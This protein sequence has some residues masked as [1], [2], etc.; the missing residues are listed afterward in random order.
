MTY[1][2]TVFLH[3]TSEQYIPVPRL[4]DRLIPCGPFI[5]TK[6]ME[7]GSYESLNCPAGRFDL[8]A[9]LAQL[10]PSQRPEAVVIWADSTRTLEPVNL[11]QVPGKRVLIIGDTHHQSAPI[12]TLLNYALSE[13]YDAYAIVA[14]PHHA[15][16]FRE[17]GCRPLYWFP[18]LLTTP[19]LLPPS[20]ER[21]REIALIGQ[22]GRIHPRRQRIVEAL[23]HL[24][25]PIRA[26][27]LFMTEG[28]MWYNR[29]LISLN[30]SL[31]GDLNFRP[32]EI[33]AAGGFMLTDRLSPEAGLDR[34]YTEGQHYIAYDSFPD[35]CDK[36]DH[37]LAHPREAIAIATVA[38]RHYL[39]TMSREHVN[40]RFW[41]AILNDRVEE[42][43]DLRRDARFVQ[44]AAVPVPPET[45]RQAIGLYEFVQELHRR[46]EITEVLLLSPCRLASDI[47]DM[48]RLRLWRRAEDH[49]VFPFPTRTVA[50]AADEASQRPWV[51]VAIAGTK[52]FSAARLREILAAY[53]CDHLIIEGVTA[54]AVG[55][56][57]AGLEGFAVHDVLPVVTRVRSDDD[58]AT[59]NPLLS[60]SEALFSIAVRHHQGG[61]LPEAEQLYR[62]L[63]EQNPENISACNNLGVIALQS[64]CYLEAERL[65]RRA[66]S[67][68]SDYGDAWVTLQAAL[69]QQGKPEEHP[70]P[71]PSV[72]PSE[73]KRPLMEKQL[74][75]SWPRPEGSWLHIG[76]QVRQDK[77]VVLDALPG[78]H[79]DIIGDC[80]DLSMISDN[81]CAML[82]L[83]HV[84][85]HLGYNDALPATLRGFMRVLAPSGLLMA[86]VPD[87]AVLCQLFI[88]PNIGF[89]ERFMA[90][91]MMFGGRTTEY[92][93]HYTGFNF[94]IMNM[95]LSESGFVDIRK[96]ESFGF[97]N[98]T[99][100]LKFFNIPVS[101]N[102]TARKPA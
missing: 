86:S 44:A 11:S 80:R 77:W 74:P 27:Q 29:A 35:L 36:I 52:E 89:R 73:P 61:R 50:V 45:L 54:A 25:Y 98:D 53:S 84:L 51:I 88:H 57:A 39:S 33:I 91:R 8:A 31:N 30:V 22:V 9:V 40:R 69:K 87:L 92:D 60:P 55:G 95:Y 16:F 46:S 101:L 6:Q 37:Y 5:E 100:E 94:E 20:E 93:I 12:T 85:E 28:A 82:Y 1:P 2:V 96:V 59:Q 67:L 34:F 79:V 99:S 3:I 7:D 47:V 32:Y 68:K 64:G 4:S 78:P 66:L 102:V 49:A 15:H 19:V 10:L 62:R 56:F 42:P 97:F 71:P 81:S 18:G 70:R 76:G 41:N 48:P 43:F 26:R 58:A 14:T 72:T 24:G 13:P 38:Q 83:S 75:C 21:S 63:I 90:M 17:A 23:E 65:A